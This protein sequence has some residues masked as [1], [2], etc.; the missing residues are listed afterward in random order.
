MGAAYGEQHLPTSDHDLDVIAV[1]RHSTNHRRQSKPIQTSGCR[2]KK[3]LALPCPAL[4]RPA[5]PRRKKKSVAK[6]KFYRQQACAPKAP[7]DWQWRS[8]PK[9]R[10]LLSGGE[11]GRLAIDATRETVPS[12][13]VQLEHAST[14]TLRK[15]RTDGF[16][17]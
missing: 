3:V 14:V 8:L 16:F 12:T 11:A 13:I 6:E 1:L 15:L 9:K 17:C 2:E 10:K 4:P 5:L 7:R